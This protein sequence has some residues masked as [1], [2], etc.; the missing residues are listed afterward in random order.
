MPKNAKDKWN[1]C[2]YDKNN[3][4]RT[5]TKNV[6]SVLGR[7][8][9]FMHTIAFD[10]PIKTENGTIPTGENVILTGLKI[11]NGNVFSKKHCRNQ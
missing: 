4:T 10:E 5:S 1:L 3:I 7:K 2:Q 8:E 9:I 6:P 11:K